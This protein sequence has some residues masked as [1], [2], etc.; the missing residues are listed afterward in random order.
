MNERKTIC[1]ATNW[2]PTR[3]NP[4][5]GSF[6]REQALALSDRF[7]FVVVRYEEKKTPDP[8]YWLK[9]LTGKA[10]H[11]E[12]TEQE[13]NIT[14]YDITGHLPA[15]LWL[16]NKL[17]GVLKHSD[18]PG[19]GKLEAPAWVKARENL[20]RKIF[21]KFPRKLHLVYSVSA[22]TEASKA[23]AIAKAVGTGYV[24]AEHGPFPWPGS[25]LRE[26]E[27][28]ALE[29]ADAFLAI[30]YDKVRQVM[31]QNIRP[32][33]ICYV[34][35]LVDEEK[36]P[37]GTGSG[38]EKTFI[39]VAAHS[40]YKNYSLFIDI[41][42]RLT[43]L[44]DVP[45]RVMIVGYN[46]NKGYSVAADELERKIASSRFADRTEMIP[47]VSRDEIHKLYDRA[48]AFVM[49]SVQEGMPVSALEA[50]CC[51]LPIFSTMCGGVED[52]V[53]DSVGRILN[54]VDAE[55]FANAL[56]AYLE[57]NITFDRAHIRDHVVSRYG[58]TAF[59]DNMAD[60]FY[61]AMDSKKGENECRL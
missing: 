24:L 50:G 41:F 25:V 14:V 11:V 21:A 60:V 52:Y 7:D 30:S 23:R 5:V 4:F 42:D 43:Q 8:V 51:G 59:T 15:G 53:D 49:T 37:L 33:K 32:R 13:G 57:G 46:A 28:Q 20:L 38:G 31:L 10:F 35:N 19:A 6:F 3:E 17:Y 2:Y 34:G 27:R 18:A 22:Q 48:D 44:T 58:R 12:Q 47:A 26:T 45:F 56:K 40:F 16:Y 36:F 9:C 61:Y 39:M 29:E 54:I 1:L 55:G